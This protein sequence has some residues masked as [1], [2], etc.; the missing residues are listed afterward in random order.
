MTR[1]NDWNNLSVGGHERRAQGQICWSSWRSFASLFR[2]TPNNRRGINLYIGISER[3]TKA[4]RLLSAP[5]FL[6]IKW[7]NGG[8]ISEI[9]NR[10]NEAPAAAALWPGGVPTS[11]KA[12][13]LI[14]QKERTMWRSLQPSDRGIEHVSES[15]IV[16]HWKEYYLWT[17][18]RVEKLQGPR[19][20]KNH[21]TILALKGDFN[22]SIWE[23]ERRP[24]PCSCHRRHRH[25]PLIS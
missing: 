23:F 11:S 20:L 8:I 6:W 16:Q 9:R 4:M 22:L 15:T 24:R 7:A 1:V 18:Q 19:K 12:E 21:R 10:N 25:P 3:V 2:E 14:T 5:R 17:K 13:P